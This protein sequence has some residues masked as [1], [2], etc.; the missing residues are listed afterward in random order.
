MNFVY[1]ELSN[2]MAH[3]FKASRLQFLGI[4]TVERERERE[5]ERV[6]FYGIYFV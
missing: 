4:L 6:I 1:V 2:C 5:R 3:L